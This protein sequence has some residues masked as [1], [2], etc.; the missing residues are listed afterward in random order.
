MKSQNEFTEAGRLVFNPVSI[1]CWVSGRTKNSD[2]NQS[3]DNSN[4]RRQEIVRVE[5]E[6]PIPL[7]ISRCRDKDLVMETGIGTITEVENII[8]CVENPHYPAEERYIGELETT[9]GIQILFV[10]DIPVPIERRNWKAVG[11]LRQGEIG[12]FLEIADHHGG[13]KYAAS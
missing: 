7:V 6:S 2:V 9:A 1:P 5:D 3:I 13:G 8:W 11:R 10:S 4:K 12:Y